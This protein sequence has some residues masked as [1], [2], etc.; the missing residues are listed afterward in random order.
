MHTMLQENNKKNEIA[1]WK[2]NGNFF[3]IKH[4]QFLIQTELLQIWRLQS[5]SAIR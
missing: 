3:E 5:E 4:V 2:F 1:N